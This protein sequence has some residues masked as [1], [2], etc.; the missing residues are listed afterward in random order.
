MDICCLKALSV[1]QMVT[2]SSCIGDFNGHIGSNVVGYEGV[3]AG[4]GE[5]S[6]DGKRLLEFAK[7]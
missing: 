2:V 1:G 5:R 4:Y 7:S 6:I 3:H